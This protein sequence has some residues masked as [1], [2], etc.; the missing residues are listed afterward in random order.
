MGRATPGV[1]P[2]TGPEDTDEDDLR[3]R[4]DPRRVVSDP[5]DPGPCSMV[6]R[7]TRYGKVRCCRAPFGGTPGRRFRTCVSKCVNV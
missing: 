7:R 5:D 3:P 6:Y 4:L 1:T 2:D